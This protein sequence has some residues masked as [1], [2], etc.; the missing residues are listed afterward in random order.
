MTTT[1]GVLYECAAAL[2]EHGV[3]A[4]ARHSQGEVDAILIYPA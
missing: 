1:I 4:V 2:R 3:N